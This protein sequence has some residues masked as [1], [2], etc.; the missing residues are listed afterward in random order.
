MLSEFFLMVGAMALVMVVV[1]FIA[2]NFKRTVIFEYERG[3]RYRNGKFVGVLM[4]GRY[5]HTQRTVIHKLDVR[6]RS[7]S[8]GGQEVLSSDGVSLR[9][10]LIAHYEI[11][12]VSHA[13]NKIANFEQSLYSELQSEL[14]NLVG[15]LKIDE[16]LEQRK[17]MAARLFEMTEASAVQL[18]VRLV[19]V[20]VRDIM[21]TGEFKKMLAQVVQA[22]QQGRAALEKARG[23]S[24][25][26]RNL[27]NAAK[28]IET[29]PALLQLRLLQT[30]EASSGNTLVLEASANGLSHSATRD[31]QR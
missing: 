5:H 27:A 17:A 28:L 26:L 21:L 15:E 13:F 4:P 11:I 14:R 1:A 6:L 30:L 9:I 18:G 16:L 23:E 22:R 29:S 7:V 3:L 12:D 19:G 2:N 31:G 25:A 10:S 8:V 20:N 24:A